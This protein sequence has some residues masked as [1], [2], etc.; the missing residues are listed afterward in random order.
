[1]QRYEHL[2]V[3]QLQF[4]QQYTV[5]NAPDATNLTGAVIYVT[6]G[7]AGSPTLAFSDGTNW[8]RTDTLAA[9]STV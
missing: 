4:A 2:T 5:A 1:M 6:N 3:G 9:I 7:A 8:L